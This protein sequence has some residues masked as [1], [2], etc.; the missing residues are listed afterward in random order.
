MTVRLGQLL[1]CG[2]VTLAGLGLLL[3]AAFDLRKA[4]RAK[5][6][7]TTQ[8]KI[9]SS[10]LA[11]VSDSDGTTYKVAILYEYSVNG[12]SHRSDVWRLRAG[13]SSFT[14]AA[15]K[16]VERYPLGATVNVYFNPEDPADAMLEPGRVSWSLLLGGVVF[17]GM[18]AIGLLHLA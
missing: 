16:A 10:G 18:G 1:F 12:V 4:Y 5:T 11:E 3:T 14:K 7:P 13:S 15:T 9:L 8:G 2:L 17:A 6:W